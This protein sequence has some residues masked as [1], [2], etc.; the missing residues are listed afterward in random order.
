MNGFN[1]NQP[2]QIVQPRNPFDESGDD[3]DDC[4]SNKRS[5]KQS[6]SENDIEME[7][8]DVP[9][10]STSNSKP[11]SKNKGE[12]V[13][14]EFE[15]FA[16][17]KINSLVLSTKCDQHIYRKHSV[18]SL[19]TRYRC[20]VDKC[21]AF[22]VL[23]AD[24][25]TCVRLSHS[26]PHK[27]KKNEQDVETYYWDRIAMNEMRKHCTDLATIAGGKR[28]AEVRSIFANVKQQ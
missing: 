14:L 12:P 6:E 23:S 18:H 9:S 5:D 8:N 13:D 4:A 1:S 17:E 26:E 24:Q 25:K 16:G 3:D 10:S 7:L 22:V 28:I 21:Y 27:H 2:T 11:K 19:G 15:M 20:R